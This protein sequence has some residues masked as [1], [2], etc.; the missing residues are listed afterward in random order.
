MQLLSENL[1]RNPTL[2][3]A[4]SMSGKIKVWYIT[5]INTLHISIYYGCIGD[6]IIESIVPITMADFNSEINSRVKKKRREGYK[7]LKDLSLN[8]VDVV[9]DITLINILN[10][11]LPKT[12]LDL[13]FYQKPM[14]AQKFRLGKMNYPVA[15]QYKLNGIRSTIKINKVIQGIGMFSE[16]IERPFMKSMDGLEYFIPEIIEEA[17]II[18]QNFKDIALDGELYIHKESLNNINAAIPKIYESGTIGKPGRPDL[19]HRVQ[20]VTF[21][22]AIESAIQRDRISMMRDVISCKSNRIISLETYI[23]NSDE[24]AQLFTQKAISLGYEGAVFRDLEAEYKFGSRPNTMM[25]AKTFQDAEFEIIDIIPKDKQPTLGMFVCKNDINDETFK[26]NPEG[27]H[28]YQTNLLTNKSQFI[29][30]MLTVKFY[31]RSGVKQCPFHA[32]GLIIRN[33]E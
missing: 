12:N 2:L 22:L 1:L 30:K 29:G 9:G 8:I 27:D 18:L 17:R 3:F 7:S 10:A 6:S 31:E 25:K 14:K 24:E 32:N 23:I 15:G 21:D 20:F 16:T 13:N 26:V 4:R 5:R 33:Y 28:V 11:K 19:T